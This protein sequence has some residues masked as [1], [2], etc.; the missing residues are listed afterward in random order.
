MRE[1]LP[2][3]KRCNKWT[4]V[5]PDI[6]EGDI[7]LVMD[8]ATLRGCWPLARVERA[9]PGRDGRVRVVDVR[10]GSRTCTRP[11]SRLCPLEL[12]SVE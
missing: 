10:V 12:A 5:R 2:N 11:I 8:P 9:H 4:D 6:K 1:M 3:L 7:I